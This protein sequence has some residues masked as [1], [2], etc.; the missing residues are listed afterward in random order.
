VGDQAVESNHD[1][2]TPGQAQAYSYTAAASSPA[3]R[4]QAYIDAPNS[5]SSV[6]LGLYSNSGSNQPQTLLGQCSVTSVIVNAWDSCS[7][8]TP[9]AVTPGTKYWLAILGPKTTGTIGYRDSVSAVLTYGSSSTSLNT[10]PVTWST[11]PVWGSAPG[12]I[13]ASS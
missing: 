10:L 3:T 8:A 11:G 9:P 5:A 2:N 13:Y 6:V 4:L 12:S 7:L 1:S